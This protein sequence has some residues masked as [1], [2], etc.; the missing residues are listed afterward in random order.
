[1][2][3]QRIIDPLQVRTIPTK[4]D[5]R[6]TSIGE[7]S[8][9]LVALD[10]DV[11]EILRRRRIIRMIDRRVARNLSDTLHSVGCSLGTAMQASKT[12]G[13]G[14]DIKSGLEA[15][16]ERHTDTGDSGSTRSSSTHLEGSG[17]SGGDTFADVFAN[18]VNPGDLPIQILPESPGIRGYRDVT[19]AEF[20]CA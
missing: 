17:H 5:N 11:S 14:I 16:L 7:D 1:H 12:A 4:T 3:R 9:Q 20:D 2:L 18:L 19:D 13:D 6:I 10:T 15:T 8:F